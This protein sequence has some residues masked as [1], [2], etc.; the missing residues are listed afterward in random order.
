MKQGRIQPGAGS[1]MRTALCVAAALACA[2]M[3][4]ADAATQT[5]LLSRIS[6]GVTS[7]TGY[8]RWLNVAEQA[9]SASYRSQYSYDQ[10]AVQIT[11]DA[12]WLMLRGT[13]VATNLK[14]NF[15]YQLKI[16]GTPDTPANE[17]IG[18][19]GR[20]WEQ[21]WTGT[22]WSS[23]WNLNNK[24]DGS[25]P[26]PNDFLYYQRRTIASSSSPT[27]KYYR[28]TGY[29]I[30]GF[31]VTDSCGNATYAFA[32]TRSHHV[33]WKDPGVW[34]YDDSLVASFD[35]G[36]AYPAYDVDYP[37]AA[38]TIY[39]EWERLSVSGLFL[40]PSAY[41]CQIMLTEESFHS[42][43]AY[44][45][46]WAAAMG[47]PIHFT[48]LTPIPGDVNLDCRVNILD[49]VFIRNW[50]NQS[51]ATGDNRLADVNNDGAINILDLIYVRNR[52]GSTCPQ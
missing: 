1:A 46:N 6:P 23:G 31:F 12:S 10:A 2:M 43:A 47:A 52:L 21:Y 42:M 36:P 16:I 41:D 15:A 37:P 14:P 5:I 35:A 32:T 7:P 51:V 34:A 11:F 24:G 49:L 33:L 28:Y 9:Y 4:S 48:I 20:W 27:G 22:A 40:R 39:P 19:G 3:S 17:S 38:C 26:N 25:S 18:L 30:F 45:G 13:L 50:L 44:G 29:M 8:Y